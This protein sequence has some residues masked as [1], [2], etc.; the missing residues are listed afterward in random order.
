MFSYNMMFCLKSHHYTHVSLQF[1]LKFCK[2]L[3]LFWHLRPSLQF[4]YALYLLYLFDIHIKPCRY[5]LRVSLAWMLNEREAS[6]NLSVL[7][8]WISQALRHESNVFSSSRH[9]KEPAGYHNLVQKKVQRSV[10]WR[11]KISQ[12]HDK[13]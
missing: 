4:R 6:I 9:N 7:F 2:F 1:T 12:S 5:H 10:S 13:L 11:M 8:F 3:T